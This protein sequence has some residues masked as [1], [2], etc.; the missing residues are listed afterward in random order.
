MGKR[1]LGSEFMPQP[2]G[3]YRLGSALVLA[4]ASG[5]PDYI[6]LAVAVG[7][8]ALAFVAALPIIR[9]Y[10]SEPSLSLEVDSEAIHTRVEADR[11]PYIRL[12]VKNARGRRAATGSRVILWSYRKADVAETSVS[13]AGPELGW[14]STAIRPGDGAVIFGGTSRPIDFGWLGVAPA[15]PGLPT[16]LVPGDPLPKGSVWWL[17]FALG[18]EQRLAI[19]RAMVAPAPGG[20]TVRLIVGADTG[21]AHTFDVSVRWLSD[22]TDPE[23][24]LKSVEL[25]IEKLR[26]R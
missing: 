5:H 13:L 17:Q 1:G 8:I 20:Y 12:M 10:C 15:G 22:A 2:P 23:S 19:P 26:H 11:A 7:T 25:S 21:K 24:A 6:E 14:P 16:Q 3:T 9:D 18:E 4:P